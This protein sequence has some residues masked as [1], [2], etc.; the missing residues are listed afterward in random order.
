[1]QTLTL[2][3]NSDA[4]VPIHI[5][6]R[7]QIKLKIVEI[8]FIPIFYKLKVVFFCTQRNCTDEI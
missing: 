5:L 6:K 7:S 2:A 3:K 1:M 8:S 4:L